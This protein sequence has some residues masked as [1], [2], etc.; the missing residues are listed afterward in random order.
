[1]GNTVLEAKTREITG[2]AVS[3]LRENGLIPAVIYG[4]GQKNVNLEIPLNVFQKVYSIAGESNLVDLVIDGGQA[5]KVLISEVQYEPTKSFPVHVDFHQVRMDEKINAT[6]PL[7]FAGE[8]PATKEL[9]AILV[10]NFD[11]LEVECLPRDLVDHFDVD[12]GS[13][14]TYADSIRIKDLD[15]PAKI[16][17]LVDENTTVVGLTEPRAEEAPTA[18]AAES[19]APIAEGKGESTAEEKKAE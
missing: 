16:K 3:Q 10:K 15:R 19:A 11:E 2:K 14:K 1:M 18:S 4:H 12:L 17:I 7:H 8:A 13:L 6:I 9:G 5:V